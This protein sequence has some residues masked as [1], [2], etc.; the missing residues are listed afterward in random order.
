MDDLAR[1]LRRRKG[2]PISVGSG[3]STPSDISCRTPSPVPKLREVNDGQFGH[4]DFTTTL[5][6]N[7][8]YDKDFDTSMFLTQVSNS[9]DQYILQRTDQIE[10]FLANRSG[11][12]RSSSPRQSFSISEHLFSSIKSHYRSSYESRVWI[13]NSNG[14]FITLNPGAAKVDHEPANFYMYF[15]LAMK[16]LEK[17]SVVDFRRVLSKGFSIIEDLL[18]AQ[19][20]RTLDNLLGV[21]V[22]LLRRGKVE[23]A[24]MLR[25]Y[26]SQMATKVLRKG[27]PWGEICRI[28][29]MIDLESFEEII[30]QSWICIVDVWGECVGQFH[31]SA[32]D[33]YTMFIVY[34]PRGVSEQE[35]MFRRLL[36]QVEESPGISPMRINTILRNLG[37]NVLLQGKYGEAEKIGLEIVSRARRDEQSVFTNNRINAWDIIARSQHGQNKLELAEKSLREGFRQGCEAWGVKDS[38]TVAFMVRLEVWLREWGRGGEA[39]ELRAERVQLMGLEE[40]DT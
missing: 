2:T 7:G 39:D 5:P 15:S 27:S 30:V 4:D 20:P 8:L 17:D 1:Y 37:Y 21:F 29:G 40:M 3:S 18:R 22:H 10:I 28:L 11:I 38:R 33:S 34:G 31:A 19:H 16:L 25:N 6:N 35:G 14:Y 12:L 9:V 24:S 13:T 26:I 32:L 23:I 36:A